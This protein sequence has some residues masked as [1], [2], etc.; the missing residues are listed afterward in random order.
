MHYRHL[1]GE[2]WINLEKA[3][4]GRAF[5]HVCM[6]ICLRFCFSLTYT[7]SKVSRKQL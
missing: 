4:S 7:D 2:R 6:C 5:E 1:L 3:D